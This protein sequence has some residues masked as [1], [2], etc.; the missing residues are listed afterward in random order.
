MQE[1]YVGLRTM[2]P[3]ESVVAEGLLRLPE[4]RRKQAESDCGAV[5]QYCELFSTWQCL[6][7]QFSHTIGE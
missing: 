2:F 6:L 7:H 3:C 4:A 5:T 1:W